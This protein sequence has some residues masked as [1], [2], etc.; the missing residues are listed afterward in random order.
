MQLYDVATPEQ[1]VTVTAVIEAAAPMLKKYTYGKHI[2]SR[3]GGV[4]AQGTTKSPSGSPRRPGPDDRDRRGG[5]SYGGP[6]S[7]GGGYSG[8]GFR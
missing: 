8:P 4:Y 3:L 5:D 6:P 2:L 7:R 1:R